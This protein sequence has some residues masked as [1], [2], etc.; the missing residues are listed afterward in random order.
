MVLA[1]TKVSS[2]PNRDFLAAGALV[3]LLL[4]GKRFDMSSVRR[5]VDRFCCLMKKSRKSKG[6]VEDVRSAAGHAQLG[7]SRLPQRPDL[8]SHVTFRLRSRLPSR[9][10]VSRDSQFSRN[11]AMFIKT[12]CALQSDLQSST[13]LSKK[14]ITGLM[15]QGFNL[16][17]FFLHS[18]LFSSNL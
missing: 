6:E 14:E 8:V 2:M 10:S 3:G 15:A 16:L 12:S 5:K 17:L 7:K 11:K 1:S 4:G 13:I 18:F 9:T